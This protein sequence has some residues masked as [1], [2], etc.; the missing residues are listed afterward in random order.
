MVA[1]S[2]SG[3]VTGRAPDDV[4]PPGSANQRPVREPAKGPLRMDLAAMV[5]SDTIASSGYLSG[6]STKGV[7]DLSSR[8]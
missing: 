2:S 7:S 6:E 5:P 8:R 1:T 3:H 4:P